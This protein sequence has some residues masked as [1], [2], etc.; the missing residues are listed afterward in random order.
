MKDIIQN[1]SKAVINRT[2]SGSRRIVYEHYDKLVSIWYSFGNTEPL[3]YGVQSDDFE[4]SNTSK[5]VYDI[6]DNYGEKIVF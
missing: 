6:D 5:K 4:D 2:L 3:S 1:Y